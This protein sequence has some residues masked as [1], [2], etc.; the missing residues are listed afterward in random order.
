[1]NKDE[2][3]YDIRKRY[4]KE[5]HAWKLLQSDGHAVK[6]CLIEIDAALKEINPLFEI[7]KFG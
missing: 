5:F 1:M 3:V 6:Y 2:V 7:L 4:E